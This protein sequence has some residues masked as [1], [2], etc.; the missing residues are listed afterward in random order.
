MSISDFGMYSYLYSKW[1]LIK[2]VTLSVDNCNMETG[3]RC[4][5]LVIHSQSKPTIYKILYLIV[6][7]DSNVMSCYNYVTDKLTVINRVI[8]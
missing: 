4:L 7:V 3:I 5:P 2:A 1:I 6:H 8:L